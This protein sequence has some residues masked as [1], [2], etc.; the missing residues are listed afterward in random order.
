MLESTPEL[1]IDLGLRP[2][3]E[4][5]NSNKSILS[6]R[7]VRIDGPFD[8]HI[9]EGRRISVTSLEALNGVDLLCVFASPGLIRMTTQFFPH[10]PTVIVKQSKAGRREINLTGCHRLL[11]VS[12]GL[13]PTGNGSIAVEL[14]VEKR[15]G[16]VELKCV[17]RGK[18]NPF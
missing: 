9:T 14:W 15:G 17:Q 5:Q 1:R 13:N 10:A 3:S 12:A 6:R 11:L 8:R 7:R 16:Y 2:V 18:G 4:S